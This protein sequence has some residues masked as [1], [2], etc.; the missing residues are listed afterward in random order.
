LFTDQLSIFAA[1]GTPI[2][3]ASVVITARVDGTINAE[4]A[5][6]A[7]IV[8][9][10]DPFFG[11]STGEPAEFSLDVPA[12]PA[13]HY[14]EFLVA[15]YTGD[16]SRGLSFNFSILVNA[17]ADGIGS[18]TADFGNTGVITNIQINDDS[19][20]PIPGAYYT[21]A[22][23][24]VYGAAVPEPASGLLMAIGCLGM[25]TIAMWRSRRS[26][27][28]ANIRTASRQL[29]ASPTASLCTSKEPP[30]ADILRGAGEDIKRVLTS[31]LA[32]QSIVALAPRNAS[33]DGW[34]IGFSAVRFDCAVPGVTIDNLCFG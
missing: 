16:V 20:Q 12:D 31:A 4:G 19:G 6:V 29:E 1:D 34:E 25:A 28:L 2:T 13:G 22:S 8:A 9:L 3:S 30:V 17:V 7:S 33:G 15:S 5:G 24:V 32:Q 27:S 23:G 10:L 26:L 11:S 18:A 21:S 14:D